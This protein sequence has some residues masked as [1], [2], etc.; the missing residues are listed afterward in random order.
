MC[1]CV[2]TL[3]YASHDKPNFQ[4][5]KAEDIREIK[6]V[7]AAGALKRNRGTAVQLHH[8]SHGKGSHWIFATSQR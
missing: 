5:Q 7:S 4:R 3:T 8:L 1:V 2:R 6:K